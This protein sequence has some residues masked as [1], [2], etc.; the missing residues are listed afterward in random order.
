MAPDL[1]EAWR[2]IEAEGDDGAEDAINFAITCILKPRPGQSADVAAAEACASFNRCALMVGAAGLLA[3]TS[4]PPRPGVA[5]IEVVWP[6]ASG[7]LP[8]AMMRLLS[9]SVGIKKMHLL[10]DVA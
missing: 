10:R 7:I 9:E 4:T 1:A 6:R 5:A 2:K 3:V 8:D